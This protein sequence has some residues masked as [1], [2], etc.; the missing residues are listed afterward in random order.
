MY[1]ILTASRMGEQMI[2]QLIEWLL[3][4][5]SYT[6]TNPYSPHIRKMMELERQDREQPWL[7]YG[8]RLT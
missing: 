8:R 3:G 1:M 6:H 5:S 4:R 2:R 7:K